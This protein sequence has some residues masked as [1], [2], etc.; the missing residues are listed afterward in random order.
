MSSGPS[1]GRPCELSTGAG[2]AGG[3]GQRV[4]RDWA[5]RGGRVFFFPRGEKHSPEK[6]NP[7]TTEAT[8]RVLV[9]GCRDRPGSAAGL[10]PKARR[11]AVAEGCEPESGAGLLERTELSFRSFARIRRESLAATPGGRAP[12]A[13]HIRQLTKPG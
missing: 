8:D 5:E 10:S 1:L 3:N 9:T 11:G 4:C 6:K 12:R 2:G 7:P 13:D